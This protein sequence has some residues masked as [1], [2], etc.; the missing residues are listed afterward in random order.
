MSRYISRIMLD[1]D[2]D[3][4]D[5]V[6]PTDGDSYGE[7][8]RLWSL[9]SDG[10][11]RR[12]DFVYRREDGR[13]PTYLVVSARVPA[14]A[15]EAWRID[16]KPYHPQLHAGQSLRFVLRANPVVRSRDESG[17]QHRHDV[18]M[19]AKRQTA[20]TGE[21]P[22]EHE[23]LEQAAVPW[24]VERG[25]RWGFCAD[26]GAVV[27]DNYYQH[28]IPR[29]TG[30]PITFSSVDY[31]GLLTVA[32]PNRLLTALADGIGPSK[33]FGCGLLLVRPA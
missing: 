33:A 21:R 20:V 3:P 8:Q 25:D 12:R 22:P 19:R 26:P 17:K 31:Q 30:R 5:L 13:W 6:A 14:H 1:P 9:F 29:R 27:A 7:H 28:R 24:L 23:L 32:E 11:D 2:A 16:T 10:P 4:A 18:V 15:G